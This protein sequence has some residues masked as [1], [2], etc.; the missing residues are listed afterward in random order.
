VLPIRQYVQSIDR[1]KRIDNGNFVFSEDEYHSE[2]A[3]PYRWSNLTQIGIL[4]RHKGLFVGLSMQD[5]NLRRLIDVTHRQYPEI[6]NYTILQRAPRLPDDDAKSTIL[7]NLAEYVEEDSFL[8]IG[9]KV[10]WVND[11]R[12]DVAPLLTQIAELP[13]E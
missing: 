9:V 5:P 11:I 1:T 10:L 8:K 6:W 2:Y 3:D 4:S 12:T 7:K 13:E